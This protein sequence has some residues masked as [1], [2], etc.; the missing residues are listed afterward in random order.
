MAQYSFTARLPDRPTARPTSARRHPDTR[1]STTSL[2]IF[3]S[4]VPTA[5]RTTALHGTVLSIL[6]N[7][8]APDQH[9]PVIP[10]SHRQPRCRPCTHRST[11]PPWGRVGG[12]GPA[13]R[14]V[15]P[16]HPP[17]LP[18]LVPCSPVLPPCHRDTPHLSFS[19]P[20]Y[21]TVPTV[22]YRT[23]VLC[24]CSRQG[25]TCPPPH[26]TPSTI[27]VPP[28]LHLRLPPHQP[29]LHCTH[30]GA[31]PPLLATAGLQVPQLPLHYCTVL[32]NCTVRTA[33]IHIPH[34]TSHIPHPQPLLPLSVALALAL[35]L[36]L[37]PRSKCVPAFPDPAQTQHIPV[38]SRPASPLHLR[39]TLP[40]PKLPPPR[41]K[42]ALQVSS[43][44]LYHPPHHHHHHPTPSTSPPHDRGRRPPP[45]WTQMETSARG[46]VRARRSLAYPPAAPRR[47]PSPVSSVPALG[48]GPPLHTR[49]LTHARTQHTTLSPRTPRDHYDS[50]APRFEMRYGYTASLYCTVAP[51]RH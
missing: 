46:L 3:I 5:R 1:Y 12:E 39:I 2:S 16:A 31:H 45:P 40:L 47:A 13:P 21:R 19:S 34:P 10:S 27:T 44:L 26:P 7:I 23:V 32:Y 14:P 20:L 50:P 33:D 30:T 43:H 42:P 15:A 48:G 9:H 18:R 29:V 25:R 35:A 6:R 28:H 37:A 38:P 51:P 8:S 11:A 24:P 49:A 36:A 41:A 22:P 4:T 17:S